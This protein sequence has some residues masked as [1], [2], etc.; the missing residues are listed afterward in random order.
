MLFQAQEWNVPQQLL[1]HAIEDD[2]N[3]PSPYASS[4]SM[5]LTSNDTNFDQE[6]VPDFSLTI[7]DNDEGKCIVIAAITKSAF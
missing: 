5:S 6:P 4:F 3:M 2:A 1:V 7:E